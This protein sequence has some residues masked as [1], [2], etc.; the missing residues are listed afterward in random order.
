MFPALRR[1]RRANK[2]AISLLLKCLLL[3]HN[4]VIF[5]RALFKTDKIYYK[6]QQKHLAG[7]ALNQDE[8][9][10]SNK[11]RS[12]FTSNKIQPLTSST[13]EKNAWQFQDEVNRVTYEVSR[14]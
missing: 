13:A 11:T 6:K 12:D 5:K 10:E 4:Y 14:F 3:N 2:S 1:G 8:I 9:L 7:Q